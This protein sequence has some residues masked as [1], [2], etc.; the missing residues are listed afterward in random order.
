MNHLSNWLN[1]V[2]HN[3]D[4]LFEAEL[5]VG[6]EICNGEQFIQSCFIK[7]F[8]FG[9]LFENSFEDSLDFRPTQVSAVISIIIVK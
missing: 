6:I 3:L 7:L 9:N 2:L 8:C 5:V 4:E 1:E